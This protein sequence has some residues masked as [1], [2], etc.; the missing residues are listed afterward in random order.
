MDIGY[1]QCIH[2]VSF[3][4]CPERQREEIRGHGER[5]R[6]C[7]CRVRTE[8]RGERARERERDR[9]AQK[10]RRRGRLLIP[11]HGKAGEGKRE[12][13]RGWWRKRSGELEKTGNKTYREH[14]EER[15]EST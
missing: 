10:R 6:E 11:R 14:T 7:V 3:P 1:T 5:E 12:R 2:A 4:D 9:H 13:K 8:R 15:K